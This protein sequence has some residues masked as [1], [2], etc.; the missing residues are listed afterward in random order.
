MGGA[1]FRCLASRYIVCVYHLT[2]A[3][4]CDITNHFG[5][6]VLFEYPYDMDHESDA[7]CVLYYSMHLNKVQVLPSLIR[8]Y[9]VTA[10]ELKKIIF[11]V[12][13]TTCSQQ[14]YFLMIQ[15]TFSPNVRLD[16]I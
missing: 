4:Y 12:L 11:D 16:L 1:L 14:R 9:N 5:V 13:K 10:N 3:L 2:L 6:T 7:K 8:N 15:T